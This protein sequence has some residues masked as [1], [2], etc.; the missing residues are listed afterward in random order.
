MEEDTDFEQV[1]KEHNITFMN[2]Y[3]ILKNEFRSQSSEIH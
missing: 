3:F 2:F 1:A